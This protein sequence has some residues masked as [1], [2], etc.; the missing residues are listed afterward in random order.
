MGFTICAVAC[1][2]E[3]RIT[4]HRSILVS[5]SH[6]DFYATSLR[7]RAVTTKSSSLRFICSTIAVCLSD[8]DRTWNR[9]YLTTSLPDDELK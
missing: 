9:V 4:I 6:V 1:L 2:V 7:V 8:N 3:V 5:R